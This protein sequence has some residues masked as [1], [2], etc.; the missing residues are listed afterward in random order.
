M[1]LKAM[2]TWTDELCYFWLIFINVAFPYMQQTYL[3]LI[4]SLNTYYLS[5]SVQKLMKS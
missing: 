1:P 5:P 4:M 3:H 2:G